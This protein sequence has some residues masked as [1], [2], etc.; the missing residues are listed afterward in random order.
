[1]IKLLIN[2]VK[3]IVAAFIA[4]LLNSCTYKIDLGNDVKGN[5]KIKT[6]VRNIAQ[7]FENI[8]VSNG[9]DV[10]L[11]QSSSKLVTVETD[12]NIQKHIIVKV[13]N[14]T[15]IIESDEDYECSSSPKVNVN[16][17]VLTKINTSSGASITATNTIKS[18]NVVIDASSASEI[19][20]DIEAENITV[21]ASSSSEI[22]INGKAIKLEIDA[23]SASD[24]N[25]SKLFANEINVTASSSS[26]VAVYP[27]LILNAKA[28]SAAN[29]SYYKI[30]KSLKKEENSS[31]SIDQ[32]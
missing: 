3:I 25:A 27:I 24:V 22:T 23:S 32:K 17:A 28:S 30:P 11:T 14:G 7:D 26:D 12:E 31:G 1:M 9:I 18:N 21:E 6:E 20:M 2:L 5:G 13:E 4:L 19:N 8:D 10:V 15:L 16:M 29:I